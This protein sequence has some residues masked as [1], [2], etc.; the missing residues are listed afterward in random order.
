MRQT[1]PQQ[2]LCH[3]VDDVRAVSIQGL[4]RYRED[5]AAES[6]PFR[7]QWRDACRAFYPSY[8][9]RF[10]DQSEAERLLTDRYPWLLPAWRSTPHWV[11]RTNMLKC[12]A[13]PPRNMHPPEVMAGKRVAAGSRKGSIVP[14][15]RC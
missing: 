15:G 7:L 12:A 11:G 13:Q 9:F 8:D 10:W 6:P 3:V 2:S 14:H 5:L 4:D 1:F